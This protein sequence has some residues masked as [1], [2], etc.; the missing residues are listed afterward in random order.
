MKKVPQK[1]KK[2]QKIKQKQIKKHRNHGRT[3]HKQHKKDSIPRKRV[4]RSKRIKNALRNFKIYY[5]NVGGLKSKLDLLQE[6][7][8][9]YQP[10]LVCI[11]ETHM[12]KEE[13][14]QIPGYSLVYRNDRSGNS[15]GILIG[16][17]DNIK[18]IS[19]ELTQE[20]KVGQSL[21]VLLTNTKKKIRIGVIYAPQENVT[22]NNELKLM[23]E[24]IREQIKIVKEEKQQILIIGD[25]NAKIGEA[26]EDNKKQVTKGRRQLLKL[27]NKENMIILNTVK[28]KCKGVWTRVQGEEKSITDYVLTDASSANTV[29][30]MKTD[31][32]KQYGLHKLC[33][34]TA[35]NENRKIYSDHN[36]ILINLDFDT[37]NEEERPKKII[38]KEGY[39]R[40][41]T[42]TEEE[43]VS[44]LLQM[45]D[46]QE[47]YSK[48]SIAIENSIKTV[49]KT[50]TKNPRKDIKELQKIRKRLR[51]EFSTT[52]KLHEKILIL[53]R[54]K[55][56]KKHITEKYKEVRSKRINR[57]VQELRENVDNGGNP[58]KQISEILPLHSG[59]IVVLS[60]K[61]M[62]ISVF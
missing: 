18:N 31:E 27:S 4:R 8:D 23:Y 30:K 61:V 46:L 16:V 20:N 57:I 51:E 44:K 26:V 15:G 3:K 40:Y 12:Q 53:E 1:Q 5:Q 39:K 41:I 55:T 43:N 7:I 9:D 56:L 29:K 52:E 33:K 37:S 22:P 59:I 24:D 10:A 54:I 36:S 28:E 49:Q 19:L 14:I 38:T 35:T 47:S 13:E 17:R 42:I 32:E 6:M 48:W 60:N 58:H 62:R 21:W 45:G 11:V 2:N 34:N 25:F 50:R